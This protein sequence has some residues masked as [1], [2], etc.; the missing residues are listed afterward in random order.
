MHLGRTP[1]I[2]ESALEEFSTYCFRR[3][4]MKHCMVLGVCEWLHSLPL[5]IPCFASIFMARALSIGLIAS[6]KLP[7]VGNPH[8]FS[9]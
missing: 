4:C 1:K 5:E 7:H 8:S 6:A 3:Y 2:D 9:L